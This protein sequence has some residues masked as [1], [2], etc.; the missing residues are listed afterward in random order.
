MCLYWEL[1]DEQCRTRV[2][3]GVAGFVLRHCHPFTRRVFFGD[4]M[5]TPNRMV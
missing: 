2:L 4:L 5:V 1:R 3:I